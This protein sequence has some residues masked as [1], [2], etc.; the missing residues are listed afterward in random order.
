MNKNELPKRLSTRLFLGKLSTPT[1]EED[2]NSFQLLHPV[3]WKKATTDEFICLYIMIFFNVLLKGQQTNIFLQRFT[4]FLFLQLCCFI[5]QKN[6]KS[7]HKFLFYWVS[8]FLQKVHLKLV[9]LH[10]VCLKLVQSRIVRS[11][12]VHS[13]LVRLKLVRCTQN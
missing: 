7:F 4:I 9:R 2:R 5:G 10:L 3:L 13:K 11:K 1:V 6:H 12:L 8:C